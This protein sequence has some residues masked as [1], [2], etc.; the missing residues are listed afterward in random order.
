MSSIRSQGDENNSRQEEDEQ[1]QEE[2][3]D[4]D[5]DEQQELI[6]DSFGLRRFAGS[7]L[8]SDLGLG[9]SLGSGSGSGSCLGSDSYARSYPWLPIKADR[10]QSM[11]SP[12]DDD[13][14]VSWP[15]SQQNGNTANQSQTRSASNGDD[16]G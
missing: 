8:G 9:S 2:L 10:A 15:N 7:K 13:V 5:Q 16:R 14:R 4:Q 3:G 11:N 1:Q 6:S 12:T